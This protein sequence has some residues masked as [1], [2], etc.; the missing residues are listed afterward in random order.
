MRNPK[1]QSLTL[2]GLTAAVTCILGPL[3]IAIPLSPVPLSFTNLALYFTAMILGCRKGTVSYLIYLLIGLI[4][5][6]VFSGFTAGPGKLLG[7]TGGYLIG[8]IFLALISGYFAERFSGNLFMCF[9]GMILG[10]A[11]TYFFGTL[12]L[13]FQANLSFGAALAAGVIPY[14]PGDAVK[15]VLGVLAGSAVRSRLFKAGILPFHRCARPSETC[16]KT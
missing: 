13:S 2:I 10:N 8:F 6:P 5:I 1:T 4:G 12:W 3:S 14:L 9:I 11:V 15:T 16:S 7:P